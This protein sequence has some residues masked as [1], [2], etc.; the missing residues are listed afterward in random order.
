MSDDTPKLYN[1]KDD[2]PPMAPDPIVAGPCPITP[3]GHGVGV[4][5]F[6]DTTFSV[7]SINER[8][9][10]QH[11]LNG[12]FG[13]RDQWLANTFPPLRQNNEIRWHHQNAVLYLVRECIKCGFFD[14]G[15]SLR[16]LGVWTEPTDR[17]PRALA[18]HQGNQI[19]QIEY[20]A[21]DRPTI[22][23]LPPGQ[24]GAHV[25]QSSSAMPHF[26]EAPV[27]TDVG[28]LVYEHFKLWNWKQPDLDSRLVLGF[29][30]GGVIVGAIQ[31]R[32]TVWLVGDHGSG[33]SHILMSLERLLS[34]KWFSF[35][36]DATQAGLRKDLKTMA[37]AVGLDEV[38]SKDDNR[39][40]AA[41]IEM[42]RYSY[43]RD[44]GGYT[45]A[46][47]DAE[48][49]NFDAMFIV[50]SIN[51][52]PMGAQDLSR[53]AILELQ[54]VLPTPD[55]R[56]AFDQS[57]MKIEKLG[58]QFRRRI[59]DQFGRFAET[60]AIYREALIRGG[61]DFRGADTWGTLLA[62]A[63]LALS[64]GVPEISDAEEIAMHLD[65][66]AT[67]Q[68]QDIVP[69]HQNAWGILC[70]APV[71][72]GTGKTR[73]RLGELM[74]QALT[75]TYSSDELKYFGIRYYNEPPADYFAIANQHQ[76]LNEVFRVSCPPITE[77]LV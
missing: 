76:A 33:K 45:R 8:Q 48:R 25:Y 31:H 70:T 7:R 14:P 11:V 46:G 24:I 36:A 3:L 5:W 61:H 44:G 26:A 27:G 30:A 29:A 51:P 20:D 74:R 2:P 4:Y 66:F 21:Q 35:Y 34:K 47:A 6:L 19:L 71:E 12:L 75:D 60:L 32:P 13:G 22:S 52:P 55:N 39:R 37:M 63:D 73:C 68:R 23:Q 77:P 50:G 1:S 59:I 15:V 10:T 54:P 62:A 57:M 38:E 56:L 53:Q 42:M 18:V 64:D 67:E 28:E 72:V 58:P 43:D 65:A 49:G 17:D 41:M 40:G 16:G 9:M 69:D